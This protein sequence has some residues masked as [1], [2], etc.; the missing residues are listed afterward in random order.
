[1]N[2]YKLGS[3]CGV[4]QLIVIT[5]IVNSVTLLNGSSMVVWLD[6]VAGGGVVGISS[7]FTWNK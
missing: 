7:K 1:M 2:I 3:Y 6:G 5:S 4:F